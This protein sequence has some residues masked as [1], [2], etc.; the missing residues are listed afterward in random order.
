MGYWKSKVLP[1]IKKVFEKNGS[2]KK[3]AAAEAV[4]SFDESKVF[5]FLTS[6]ILMILSIIFR[7]KPNK[8][9]CFFYTKIFRYVH[10]YLCYSRCTVR[11]IIEKKH[12][13]SIILSSVFS[14]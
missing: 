8:L 4:K 13:P 12:N 6:V 9:T 11:N 14:G 2:A 5:F 7:S 3:A 10:V 1:K